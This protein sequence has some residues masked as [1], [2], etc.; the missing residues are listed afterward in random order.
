M[1]EVEALPFNEDWSYPQQQ[2]VKIRGVAYDC[3]YRRNY[4]GNL[5]ALKITR[6]SDSAV[7]FNGKLT[8]K[9]VFEAKNPE[10][11]EV[12]FTLLPWTV[13]N[14]KSEVWIFYE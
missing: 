11:Y 5:I 7:V 3:F 10:T 2:R 8:E 1:A 9:N 4:Q 13:N 6:V 12:L 14:D